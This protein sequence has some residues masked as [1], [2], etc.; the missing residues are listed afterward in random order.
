MLCDT[1]AL[2]AYIEG[3]QRDASARLQA[4]ATGLSE[5]ESAGLPVHCIRPQGAIYVSAQFT[6]RDRKTPD[7]QKLDTNEAIRRYL[8][9]AAGLGAVPFQAFGL[10]GESGWFRLSIG[11]V[12]VADIE[13]LLPRIRKAIEATS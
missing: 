11:V 10:P 1:R 9:N 13:A 4:L 5:M 6:L 2:A 7:G 12:S 3:M 8:L